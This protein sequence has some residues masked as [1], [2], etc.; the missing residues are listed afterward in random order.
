MQA[1]QARIKPARN[2]PNDQRKGKKKAELTAM[3]VR[4][5]MEIRRLLMSAGRYRYKS[6]RGPPRAVRS[7]PGT[8]FVL[9]LRAPVNPPDVTNIRLC[10]FRPRFGR[11]INR[12][13]AGDAREKAGPPAPL[14]RT[15]RA[16]ASARGTVNQDVSGGLDPGPPLRAPPGHDTEISATCKH[17][18]CA[19]FAPNHHFRR[20]RAP[21][22]AITG[23]PVRR[24]GAI[25]AL[26]CEKTDT[27]QKGN[28][29]L[30]TEDT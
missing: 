20:T 10:R 27:R 19:R 3:N 12:R 28:P 11:R 25:S 8:G 22:A 1:D 23:I 2:Q 24:S 16:G 21:Q 9:K 15:V 4:N 7:R 5:A 13:Q 18:L 29:R 26:T 6:L 14:R 30:R 17:Q